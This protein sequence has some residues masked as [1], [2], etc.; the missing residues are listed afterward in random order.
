M[1]Q[2]FLTEGFASTKA[3]A[4]CVSNQVFENYLSEARSSS[5]ELSLFYSVKLMKVQNVPTHFIIG[6]FIYIPLS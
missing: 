3:P 4:L 1:L 2:T 5:F 6:A